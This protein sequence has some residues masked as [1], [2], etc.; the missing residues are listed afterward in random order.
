MSTVHRT[1]ETNKQQRSQGKLG[2]DMHFAC[3]PRTLS[4]EHRPSR[5]L[6]AGS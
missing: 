4:L 5:G 6:E 2:Q 1:R 3:V